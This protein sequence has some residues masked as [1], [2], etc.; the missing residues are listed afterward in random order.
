MRSAADTSGSELTKGSRPRIVRGPFRL[1]AAASKRRSAVARWTLTLAFFV[2]GIA[3]IAVAAGYRMA[4]QNDE[5]C[6]ERMRAHLM[7]ALD[8]HRNV[9]GELAARQA[10]DVA[11]A[12]SRGALSAHD[13]ATRG[14]ASAP[15]YRHA[16]AY[17]L[18]G[19]GALIVSDPA[20][21]PAPPAVTRLAGAF[22]SR[23]LRRGITGKVDPAPGEA[24][25]PVDTDFL[26]VDGR[27]LLAAVAASR[28]PGEGAVPLVLV[29]TAAFDEPV[30]RSLEKASG[31]EGLRFEAEPTRHDAGL[32][33]QIDR[34][35]RI[36]GW[37]S[38]DA[39]RP[40][41]DAMLSLWPLQAAVGAGFLAFAMLS[42]VHIRRTEL[43]LAESE[44]RVEKAAC[45]DPLTG[46]PN[47]RRTL[48]M[49]DR[50]LAER[51]P[52]QVVTF[53]FLDLDVFRD[54][55]EVHGHEGGDQL[56]AAVAARLRG[57]LPATATVGRIDGDEF[58]VIM[59]VDDA[60]A[61]INA[62]SAGVRALSGPFWIADQQV[63]V[64]ASIGLSEAPRD[65]N[66]RGDLIRRA[67]LALRSAKQRGRGRVVGFANELEQEMRERRFIERELRRALSENTLDVHY[68]PIVAG[69]GLRMVGVEALLRWEHPVRGNIPPAVFVSVAE[70]TGMM[71]RL[72]EFVLRRALADA[73]PWQDL[74]VAV[75]LSPVQMRDR[76]LVDLVSTVIAESGIDPSRVVL[77]ITEGVLIENPEE[78]KQRLKQLRAL[79]LKIALDDFGSGY[80]SLSYLRRLPIDKLKIDKEFVAPLGRSANGGV[81]VQAIIALGRALGLSVLAEG[82]E[83]EEQRILLRLAGCD[84]MQGYLFS[85]AVP[86]TSIDRQILTGEAAPQAE[87]GAP[88]RARI[89]ET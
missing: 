59:T 7:N 68:Q 88:R 87:A 28:P 46:L 9:F 65:G 35:G 3:L 19:G 64:G 22:L 27:P 14:A 52:D 83:K 39:R 50:A 24:P 23:H 73:R 48:E 79:G 54:V 72:G 43:G 69:D 37:F 57:A 58:A 62:A 80:S 20:G 49:L 10:R 40:M 31:V 89:A 17:V 82:V 30:I 32:H 67:D 36:V 70:Q 84:E 66:T 18:D 45:E 53:A 2:T 56:L 75:N 78:A 42:M 12:E 51:G 4:A 74:F 25:A 1:F 55:N 21:E 26:L 86:R 13:L 6:E 5:H 29:V 71:P 16:A 11:A 38:W 34:R 47:R 63:Q 41:T 60:S 85:A 81:I 15:R 77:E 44:G 76:G 33:S 8:E 61:A